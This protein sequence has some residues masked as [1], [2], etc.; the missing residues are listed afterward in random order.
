M[1]GREHVGEDG[2]QRVDRRERDADPAPADGDA[3]GGLQELVADRVGAGAGERR[4]RQS[5]LAQERHQ[6]TGEGEAQLV[7]AHRGRRGP[8]RERP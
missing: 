2:L 5:D 4:A 3:G 6:D 7:G 1:P 8:V